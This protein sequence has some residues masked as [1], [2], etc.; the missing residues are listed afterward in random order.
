MKTLNL[1]FSSDCSIDFGSSYRQ[2]RHGS[3]KTRVSISCCG[4]VWRAT[5]YLSKSGKI[6]WDFTKE[7]VASLDCPKVIEDAIKSH[8]HLY[9]ATIK[10]AFSKM[11]KKKTV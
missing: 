5:C 6:S 2:N 10:E 7:S 11:K 4:D 3:K 8:T 1:S 9:E